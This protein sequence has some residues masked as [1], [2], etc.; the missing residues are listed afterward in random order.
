MLALLACFLGGLAIGPPHGGAQDHERLALAATPG[1]REARPTPPDAEL[2][3]ITA[4]DAGPELHPAP[5]RRDYD[6]LRTELPE[7]LQSFAPIVLADELPLAWWSEET[8]SWPLEPARQRRRMPRRC[9]TRGGYREH[10]SGAR[11]VPTATGAAAA[12]AS[13][14]GLGERGTAMVMMHRAPYEAWL[15]SI[16]GIDDERQL[17]FPVPTGHMGRGFGFTR[18][19]ELRRRRH[20]GIDI[21]APEGSPIVAARGGLV[22]VSD[23]F[24]TGYG[25]MVMILHPDGDATFYAHCRATFVAAGE[26]VERGQRIGEVGRTGFA[27]GSHLHFELRHNGA[28]R[29]PRR[30][31]LPREHV[32]DDGADVVDGG[33]DEE[34]EALGG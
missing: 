16:E 19:G 25:N 27:G 22:V 31:F 4:A 32:E 13:Y 1:P 33:S 18:T 9:R 24:I 30:R 7:A 23:N 26:I 5:P 17:T 3:V 29:D 21:G 14:F 2:D 8:D 11:I 34:A 20:R 28:S 12:L 6:A 15:A 10:C